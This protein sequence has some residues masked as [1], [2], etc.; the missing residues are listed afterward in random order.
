M[1]ETL[2]EAYILGHQGNDLSNRTKAATCLKHYIGYSV[3]FNGRDRSNALIP[4]HILRERF[5]QPFERAVRAGAPCVMLNSGWVNGIPGHANYRYITEILKQELGFADGFVISDWEDVVRLHT[6]DKMASTP[7][8][9]VRIAVMA[10]LDVSM[11]PLDYS[12]YDLCL[13]LSSEDRLFAQRV[14]DAVTRLLRVKDRL[15]LFERPY[16]DAAD[17]DKIGREESEM[18]NLEVARESII[19]AKNEPVTDWV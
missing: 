3:P 19:L 15:G 10:G 2:G 13:E 4:E 17:L 9:A 16:P 5:L 12:F 14:D 11:V 18:F 7:K 1:S 8:E 6:R